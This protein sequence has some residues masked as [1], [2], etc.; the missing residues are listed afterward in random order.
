[1]QIE[2]KMN[3]LE[4]YLANLVN[5]IKHKRITEKLNKIDIEYKRIT[6]KLKEVFYIKKVRPRD[7][8]G[9][10]GTGCA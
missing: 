8:A 4:K 10:L 9:N 1:M 3:S 2:I 6:D 5:N 7:L